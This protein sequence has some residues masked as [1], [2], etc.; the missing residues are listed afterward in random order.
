MFPRWKTLDWPNSAIKL[1]AAA[2]ALNI[3]LAVTVFSPSVATLKCWTK[4]KFSAS[5]SFKTA[6]TLFLASESATW[7]TWSG[8]TSSASTFKTLMSKGMTMDTMTAG[9]CITCTTSM[10]WEETTQELGPCIIIC[11][12]SL[13][14]IWCIP[15][16]RKEGID[17]RKGKIRYLRKSSILW[18]LYDFL[19]LSNILNFFSFSFC[20]SY[21]TYQLFYIYS[22]LFMQ[23]QL[24]NQFKIRK[25]F[26]EKLLSIEFFTFDF[27][28]I[29]YV[30]LR[31]TWSIL[32]H[33]CGRLKV[34]PNHAPRPK[35]RPLLRQHW[36]GQTKISTS[37]LHHF[38]HRR[39]QSLP[40]RQHESCPLQTFYWAFWVRCRLGK[41]I[42][43]SQFLQC[44]QAISEWT[45]GNIL[46]CWELNRQIVWNHWKNATK[47]TPGIKISWKKMSVPL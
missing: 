18:L 1:A 23:S 15:N 2:S 30:T 14:T 46:L 11:R 41:S 34:L 27:K 28:L 26:I 36:H 19:K 31:K 7:R 25:I 35:S 22:N 24:I 16:N 6:S 43:G 45:Q 32:S 33:H 4:T 12:D 47:N 21:Y 29:T 37:R 20:S 39:T 17:F 40:R 9:I 38:R 42:A 44:P 8:T 3:R 13:S 5:V 10:D